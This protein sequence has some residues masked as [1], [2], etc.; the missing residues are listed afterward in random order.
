M[1]GQS[2]L[3]ASDNAIKGGNQDTLR[4]SLVDANSKAL[5]VKKIPLKHKK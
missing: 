4:K 2:R 1:S 5:K 3:I